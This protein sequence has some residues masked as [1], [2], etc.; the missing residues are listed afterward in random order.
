MDPARFQNVV[1]VVFG[2]AAVAVAATSQGRLTR[3]LTESAGRQAHRVVGPLGVRLADR[4]TA[5][6]PPRTSPR[7]ESR[8]DA[9]RAARHGA[10]RE[11]VHAFSVEPPLD[12]TDIAGGQ[13]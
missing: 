4:A 6:R 1:N 7:G 5:P 9:R 8:W 10:R 13:R 2:V 3:A 12:R 11:L